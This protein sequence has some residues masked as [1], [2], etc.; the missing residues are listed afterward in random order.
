MYAQHSR[1]LEVAIWS[2][3]DLFSGEAI[4][5]YVGWSIPP[6]LSRQYYACLDLLPLLATDSA[7]Q[8][9]PH[10]AFS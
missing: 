6:C 2:L 8:M 3:R 7:T 5:L 9:S 10:Y 4:S 1:A